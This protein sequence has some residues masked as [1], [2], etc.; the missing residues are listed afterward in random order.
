MLKTEK[1][2]LRMKKNS[3]LEFRELTDFPGYFACSDGNIY[4]NLKSHEGKM[5]KKPLNRYI[6]SN[7]KTV[8]VHLYKDGKTY[9]ICL[10]RL[11]A[12]AFHGIVPSLYNIGHKDGNF[13][14]NSPENLSF[15]R[16]DF[17]ESNTENVIEKYVNTRDKYDG[18]LD[19]L[20][21]RY[22]SL[23]RKHIKYYYES[24]VWKKYQAV[25][26]KDDLRL[27]YNWLVVYLGSLNIMV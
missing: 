7:T 23:L 12:S 20:V 19:V 10:N 14:N 2:I 15:E 13:L 26:G 27:R 16:N 17:K 1:A 9:G 22:E 24:P 21:K 3:G 18:G 6:P 8:I 11:I 5:K 4:R 25:C